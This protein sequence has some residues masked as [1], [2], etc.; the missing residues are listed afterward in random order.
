M[1]PCSLLVPENVSASETKTLSHLWL[2]CFGLSSTAWNG[3][4][5]AWLC[6]EILSGT[7]R[8]IMMRNG[9]QTCR[10]LL[11]RRAIGRRWFQWVSFWSTQ[12]WNNIHVLA[13]WLTFFSVT[14]E[15]G[16]PRR[17]T[18]ALLQCCLCTDRARPAEPGHENPTESW[19]LGVF[20]AF[21]NY[22]VGYITLDNL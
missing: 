5:S 15:L 1:F 22:S 17:H 21:C 12:L 11:Q 19:R 7:R 10:Q 14:G 8:T 16:S 3:M 6:T 20:K 9:K 13:V 18:W 4:T 2:L